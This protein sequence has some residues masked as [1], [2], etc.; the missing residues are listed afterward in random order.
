M[1]TYEGF[2]EYW[3]TLDLT[4]KTKPQAEIE[5]A[6]IFRRLKRIVVS[7]TLETNDANTIVIKENL[8]ENLQKITYPNDSDGKM[9]GYDDAKYPYLYF[10]SPS[11]VVSFILRR[12][13]D[14]VSRNVQLQVIRFCLASR[15][16]G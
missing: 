9:C 14:F 13:S 12:Q 6:Q 2:S 10:T 5:F 11:D 3:D 1:T 16:T 7:H 4:D 8:A 15:L